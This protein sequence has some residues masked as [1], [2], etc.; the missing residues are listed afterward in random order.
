MAKIVK[1]P[2]CHQYHILQGH[3]FP[4]GITL[5][6]EIPQLGDFVVSGQRLFFF[7]IREVS[8]EYIDL[9]NPIKPTKQGLD[10]FYS[11]ATAVADRSNAL[12]LAIQVNISAPLNAFLSCLVKP[13]PNKTSSECN[14]I[15]CW[16]TPFDSL[17]FSL[18]SLTLTQPQKLDL[19]HLIYIS[20]H[21]RSSFH[22]PKVTFHLLNDIWVNAIVENEDL[23]L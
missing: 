22:G 10:L 23:I 2:H 21:R 3:S 8:S 1:C 7:P 20:H 5:Y 19:D 18:P 9:K 13:S 17:K 4:R 16:R 11:A 12:K 14:T 15:L 6:T